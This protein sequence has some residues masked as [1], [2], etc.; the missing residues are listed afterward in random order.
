MSHNPAHRVLFLGHSFIWRLED[1]IIKSNVPCVEKDFALPPSTSVQFRGVGGRTVDALRC[2]DL[3]VVASFKPNIIV[4]E[5]GSNN[6]C[7]ST[8]SVNALATN[9]V[10]LLPTLH[11][12]FNIAH[13]ILGQIIP[14]VKLPP[15]CPEY[16][17]RAKQLNH[18]LLTLLK[19]AP[20]ATFWFHP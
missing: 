9:I 20:Y 14:R 17:T 5:I 2:R 8:M 13:I 18:A 10:H 12:R 4:L 19:G 1:F 7:D 6:L 16:N 11:L 3:A 15:T